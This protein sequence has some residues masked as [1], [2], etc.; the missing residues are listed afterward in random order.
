MIPIIMYHALS[1]KGETDKY[2]ISADEFHQQMM[3]I[4]ES[5]KHGVSLSSEYSFPNDNNVII[6]FDDGHISNLKIATPILRQFGFNAT[7]FITTGNIGKGRE[8]LSWEGVRNLV[9]YGMDVQA[10]GH[11]HIFLDTNDQDILDQELGLPIKLFKEYLGIDI[12][13]FSLP[14]GRYNKATLNSAKNYGYLTISTSTPGLNVIRH[15]VLDINYLSRFVIHQ[16]IDNAEFIN[17]VN[18]DTGYV[19]RSVAKYRVKKIGKKLLGNNFYQRLWE[20]VMK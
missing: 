8:W 17:I 2:T 4:K 13:H 12:K 3:Y 15:N 6:T 14:G 20:L 18:G 9:D 7:F 16:G 19:K 5:G 10:H 11:T 1:N